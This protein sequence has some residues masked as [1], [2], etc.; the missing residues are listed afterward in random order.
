MHKRV[1]PN[2][3]SDL[4]WVEYTFVR[5]F[6]DI[7]SK[8]NLQIFKFSGEEFENRGWLNGELCMGELSLSELWSELWTVSKSELLYLILKWVA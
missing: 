8:K 1:R 4:V 6:N 7:S 5:N 2:L 3:K